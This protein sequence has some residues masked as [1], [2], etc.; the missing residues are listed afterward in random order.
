MNQPNID[1]KKKRKE[2][3]DYINGAL[4]N[5]ENACEQYIAKDTDKKQC[6]LESSSDSCVEQFKSCQLYEENE[7]DKSRANCEKIRLADTNKK[8]V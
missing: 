4:I 1:V 8:C 5:G 7:V 3:N 6:F 2:C